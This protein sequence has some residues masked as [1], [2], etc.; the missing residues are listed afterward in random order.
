MRLTKLNDLIHDSR[1]INGA[2]RLT[3][4]HTLEYRRAGSEEEAVLKG[5]LLE[6]SANRLTFRVAEQRLDDNLVGRRLSLRGRWQA[7]ADNRLAFLVERQGGR[8]NWLTLQGAWQVGPGHEIVYRF[9]RETLKTKLRRDGLLRFR[10]IWELSERKRLTYVLDARTDSTFRFRGTFQSPSV[11]AKRG[12]IRYQLG[13][14]LEGKGRRKNITL[15]GK[16]KLS[17]RL[18]LT[19]E[20][21]Y[22]DR[23]VRGIDFGTTFSL[24]PQGRVKATLTTRRGRPL[25]LEL[26]VS[27]EFLKGRGEAFAR[28]K[29]SLEELALE[30]GFRIRW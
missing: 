18:G 21:P 9:H 25:G 23:R 26:V 17:R 15:F 27:R 6:A 12:R 3:R 8:H 4:K 13:A 10:G 16:W 20:I 22:R 24:G 30:G 1:R 11:L 2:W 7:D 28:L 19:F 14:E 5:V 29:R